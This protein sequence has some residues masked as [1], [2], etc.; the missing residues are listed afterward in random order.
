MT[1]NQL[2]P[3]KYES[4]EERRQEFERILG[5][6]MMNIRDERG[7]L[8]DPHDGHELLNIYLQAEA[9]LPSSVYRYTMQI[10]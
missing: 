3:R 6:L 7:L 10:Y 5:W 4:D 2:K 1:S 8:M 9:S